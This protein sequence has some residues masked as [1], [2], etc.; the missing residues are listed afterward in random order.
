MGVAMKCFSCRGFVSCLVLVLVTAAPRASAMTAAHTVRTASIQTIEIQVSDATPDIGQTI[1]LSLTDVSSVDQVEWDLGGSGCEGAPQTAVCTPGVTDCLSWSHAYDSAGVKTV[2]A[3]LTIGGEVQPPVTTTVT[4]N[5]SGVCS[6]GGGS[7]SYDLTPSSQNFPSSGGSASFTVDTSA[8]CDWTASRSGSWITIVSGGSGT[9]PGTVVYEIPPNESIDERL[10]FIMV[11][12]KFHSISQDPI[13]VPTDF[14]V[15]DPNPVEIGQLITFTVADERLVPERWQFG[16]INC[17]ETHQVVHCSSD[18]D[19]CRSMSWSYRDPGWKTVRLTTTTGERERPVQ[20]STQGECC[21]KDA[22]PDPGF[23]MTPNPAA[24]GDVVT[25]LAD[26]IDTKDSEISISHAPQNPEI[27][28]T[29]TLTINGT[30]AVESTA[31]SF[32]ED[33]CGNYRAHYTCVPGF[34]DCLQNLFQFASSGTKVVELRIDGATDPVTTEIEVQATGSCPAG[35][36]SYSVTPQSRTFDHAGGT[37]TFN[38]TTGADCDWEPVTPAAWITIESGGGPDSGVVTYLVQE[39]T[40]GERQATITAGGRVHNVNQ[41]AAPVEPEPDDDSPDSWLWT[42]SLDGGVVVTSAGASFTHTFT[43]PGL[44]SVRLEV[45]NC[46]GSASREATLEIEGTP[47]ESG[48]DFVVPSAVHTPGLNGTSWRT[49]VVV[50]NPDSDTMAVDLSYRP[51]DAAPGSS[52]NHG[53]SLFIEPKATRIYEDVVAVIPGLIRDDDGTDSYIG[54]LGFRYSNFGQRDVRPLIVSRTYNSTAAGTFGQFVPAVS[55][56]GLSDGLLH[57]CGLVHN[58]EYRTNIRLANLS[59]SRQWAALRVIDQDGASIGEPVVVPIQPNSTTQINGIAERAG[60]AADLDVF[61]VT[62]DSSGPGVTGWASVVDNAT[63]DPV[64]YQSLTELS[65]LTN[66][67]IP[68]VAH[69]P[70][71]N[72]SLWR[73]DVTFYNQ[74]SHDL[75][76]TIEYV[77]S[78]DLGLRPRFDI[79]NHPP[80]QSLYFQDLLGVSLLPAGISSKGFLVV[81]AQNANETPQVAA[82]TY[83][84]AI[85]GGTFG[86]N[87]KVYGPDDRIRVGSSAFVP[88]VVLSQTTTEGARTNLGILNVSETDA[89]EVRVALWSSDGSGVLAEATF[90]VDPHV[91][92]QRDLATRLG[93][94]GVELKGSLEIQLLSGDA[95]VAYGSIIDNQTQD[96]ILVP[97]LPAVGRD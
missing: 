7:C 4:V 68:G 17:A 54:S 18:P 84:L 92:W 85:G 86:Q 42:V 88:G 5:A 39:N 22:A 70:G 33:G 40:G 63:G 74:T 45:E 43:D 83:N 2:Q 71:L 67:W 89:A 97:A 11:M 8:G 41:T 73:T 77:P 90:V 52:V 51:E 25:F 3:T 60:A 20:V 64:L 15:S 76:T 50:F 12:G 47:T 16:G 91:L 29:V 21:V 10:G 79:R 23:S 31:W 82:R 81:E 46:V 30:G 6:G 78:E 72:D 58:S 57:L 61:S 93:L 49:D 36:C 32:G 9:G 48:A 96:P 80:G 34:T 59:S 66:A 75:N 26:S 87:L 95:V 53:M 28:E 94:S 69:L 19:M 1:A 44:Y 56:S 13:I 14:T 65:T 27:G 38:V 62:I 24:V 37:G 35:G 55:T